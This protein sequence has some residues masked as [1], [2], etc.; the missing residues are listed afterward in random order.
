MCW[1]DGTRPSLCSGVKECETKPAH[2]F[3]F[4][5]S[6][7][8][9]RRTTVFGML[10]DSAIILVVIRRSFLA[11][12]ATAAIFTSV[13]VDSGRPRPSSSST[14]SLPSPNRDYHLKPFDR[15]RVSIPQAFCTN[16]SF[17]V[18]QRPAFKQNFIANLCLF[19]PSK[20]CKENCFCKTG[21][22]S[23]IVE[24]KQTKL[25]VWTDVDW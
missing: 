25:S 13:W 2:N 11:R 17:S 16:T 12:L 10:K 8:R 18:S 23:Y 14:S 3:L 21:Y 15:F 5:Q 1:Q 20:R 6:S 7:F 9:T 19:P 24:D 4:P 22:K